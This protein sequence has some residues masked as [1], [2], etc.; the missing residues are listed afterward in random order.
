MIENNRGYQE[1]ADE[2]FTPRSIVERAHEL[3]GEVD[4]ICGPDDR[5]VV[6][7]RIPL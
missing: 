6:Q 2:P 1:S 7:V 3:G 5:T 4:V